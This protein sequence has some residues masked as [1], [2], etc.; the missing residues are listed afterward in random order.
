MRRTLS[1][2]AG[3][4]ALFSLM[5]EAQGPAY[6]V[7]RGWMKMPSGFI[8]GTPQG[9]PPPEEREAM[10]QRGERTPNIS[11][12]A[13]VAVDQ[14]DNVYAFHRGM[15]N[16]KE[17]FPPDL[18]SREHPV[19]VWDANGT[20]KRWMGDGIPGGI[21]GPHMLEVDPEGHL[22]VVERDDH[23]VIKLSKDGHTPAWI[24]GEAG[25][26]G[27]D[28]THVNRPTDVAWSKNG[29]IFITDGYGNHRVMKFSKDY[30]FIKQWGGGPDTKSSADGQFNLPHSISIDWQDKLYILDREN[31]RIQMFDTEGTFLGKW[32]ICNCWGITIKKDGGRDGIMFM[33]DHANEQVMKVDMRN[34]KELARWGSL[35]QGPGQF[36]W[37]HDIAVDSKGAVYV[38]DTYGQKIQKFVD[39]KLVALIGTKQGDGTRWLP[40]AEP[41]RVMPQLLRQPQE[42]K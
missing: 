40:A 33:T 37:A 13:G 39:G 4:V 38:S 7:V 1:I 29:D 11:A 32:D 2:A 23:R 26:A 30:K 21:L 15:E 41:A 5:A 12:F 42:L 19:V 3:T 20:F 24:L 17:R 35:G 28:E 31:H 22:W 14:Q 36:D 8:L 16:L 27:W 34:G 10:T 25:K 9:A 6:R 18:R